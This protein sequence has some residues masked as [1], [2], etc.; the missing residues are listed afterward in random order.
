MGTTSYG[1]RCTYCRFTDGEKYYCARCHAR[2]KKEE[3]ERLIKLRN[4]RILE[5]GR[6]RELARQ[7]EI[8]ARERRRR[9]EIRKQ[10][11]LVAARHRDEELKN[12]ADNVK[13]IEEAIKR[14]KSERVNSSNSDNDLSM[15]TTGPS[16]VKEITGICSNVAN[17]GQ[18]GEAL[19]DAVD[20]IEAALTSAMGSEVSCIENVFNSY[21][22][23]GKLMSNLNS[24]FIKETKALFG[25]NDDEKGTVD[26]V[27][28]KR[29][30]E[31]MQ[32]SEALQLKKNIQ[33]NERNIRDMEEKGYANDPDLAELLK[34][35]KDDLDSDKKKLRDT[36]ESDEREYMEAEVKVW[37]SGLELQSAK[38]KLMKENFKTMEHDYEQFISFCNKN[39]EEH[40]CGQ[41]VYDEILKIANT[42][43]SVR[44]A[45]DRN[46]SKKSPNRLEMAWEGA[47]A[48]CKA[49]GNAVASTASLCISTG[50]PLGVVAGVAVATVLPVAALVGGIIGGLIGFFSSKPD[51][52]K[53]LSGEDHSKCLKKLA[54]AVK[55]NMEKTQKKFE[56]A[57]EK[58]TSDKKKWSDL[59]KECEEVEKKLTA[60]INSIKETPNLAD[61]TKFQF[62]LHKA[63][64]KDLKTEISSKMEAIEKLNNQQ[65]N[66]KQK[67]T[68]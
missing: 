54:A 3:A 65:P 15:W 56:S 41:K 39:A 52:L 57:K 37:L 20:D 53:K 19:L 34:E 12:Y 36:N 29:Q 40:G 9:E 17:A 14:V 64:W 61:L 10:E 6:R 68:T 45:L 25:V 4:D 7:R 5:E 32:Q 49:S 66:K 48:G 2:Q 18:V 60:R 59:V 33:D 21:R 67:T 46:K 23:T 47:K 38:V 63:K 30:F 16:Y 31:I 27:V 55:E 62:N 26:H 50:N 13:K 11:A 44:D 51:Q 42:I 8:E 43:P 24:T 1:Y 35:Y 28:T 22:Q 58:A